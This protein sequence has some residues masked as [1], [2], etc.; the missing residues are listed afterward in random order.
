[1]RMEIRSIRGSTACI[2]GPQLIGLYRTDESHCI[3]LDCGS[4]TI[5][6]ELEETLSRAGLTPIG[7]LATHAHFDHFGNAAY[8]QQKYGI[9][10]AISFGEAELCRTLPAIKSH[11]FVYSAGE[12]MSDP[13]LND[14]PCDVD[15]VIMPF[16]N[17][18]LF[19]GVRFGILH[20]PGHSPDHCSIITPDRVCYCGDALMCGPHLENAKLPYAYN[21][22]QSLESIERFREIGCSHL[23]VAHKGIIEAPFDRLLDDN[24]KA[25]ETQLRTVASLIDR[26]M[27]REEIFTAVR[28]TLRIRVDTPRKA[29]A[30]ERFLRPYL[31]C[32]VDD[33]TLKLSVRGTGTL[34]YEPV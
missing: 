4:A 12:I 23:L 33:G 32:L 5:R 1:M 16:E 22:R 18:I 24:R 20:T 29:E 19:C 15:R 6:E 7:I 8:F 26:Q 17:H 10:V 27:S 14:I 25:M 2:D 13:L 11:L 34:C 21:F 30:L 9:P 31:E 3:L 28:E